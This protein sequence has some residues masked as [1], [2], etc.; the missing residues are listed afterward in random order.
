[1]RE[2]P[3]GICSRVLPVAVSASHERTCARLP[4]ASRL[5]GTRLT[6]EQVPLLPSVP[7]M[8]LITDCRAQEPVN[9]FCFLLCQRRTVPQVCLGSTQHPE[10]PLNSKPTVPRKGRRVVLLEQIT[11][12]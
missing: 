5:K 7:A 11:P 3:S 2:S 6:A 9:F 12:P 1:M 4:A 10:T 8:I